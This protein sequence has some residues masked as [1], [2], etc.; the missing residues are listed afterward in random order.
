M[1][2]PQTAS[3]AD[4]R[5]FLAA[6]RYSAAEIALLADQAEF[7]LRRIGIWAGDARVRAIAESCFRAPAV[8]F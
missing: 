1:Y 5:A 2:A 6:D 4:K 7:H 3:A 8:T